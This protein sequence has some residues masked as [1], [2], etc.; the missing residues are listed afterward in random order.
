MD[1]W[2]S[3]VAG[4]ALEM[5]PGRADCQGYLSNLIERVGGRA[6]AWCLALSSGCS[7]ALLRS[8]C[9]LARAD[10]PADNRSGGMTGC[11][12]RHP[13]ACSCRPHT[14]V[15][16]SPNQLADLAP[17]QAEIT[18]SVARRMFEP[19]LLRHQAQTK[20]RHTGRGSKFRRRLS[21]PSRKYHSSS[22]AHVK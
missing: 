20:P 2:S 22:T 13:P 16:M 3:Q 10:Y 19:V 8:P 15:R 21:S 14:A 11:D 4:K 9:S 7:S 1:K 6:R 12:N 17:S 5:C 18:H